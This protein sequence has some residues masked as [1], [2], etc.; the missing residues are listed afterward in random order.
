MADFQLIISRSQEECLQLIKKS[1]PYYY[2]MTNPM[3]TRYVY[4]FRKVDYQ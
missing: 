3:E 2:D 1:I 4:K